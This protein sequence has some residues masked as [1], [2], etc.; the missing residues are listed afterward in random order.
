MSENEILRL[1]QQDLKQVIKNSDKSLIFTFPENKNNNLP[2]FLG[3]KRM[4]FA[5]KTQRIIKPSEIH[6]LAENLNENKVNFVNL[7]NFQM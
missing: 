4:H 6:D 5:L 2:D 1:G 3:R 7:A